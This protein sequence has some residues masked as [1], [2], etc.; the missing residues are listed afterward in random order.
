MHETLLR[1]EPALKPIEKSLRAL[2]GVAGVNQ[3]WRDDYCYARK[4]GTSFGT[5][6]ALLERK[7]F[8]AQSR[9]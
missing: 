3:G 2:W 9:G 1:R 7:K 6:A 8:V 5:S 4:V